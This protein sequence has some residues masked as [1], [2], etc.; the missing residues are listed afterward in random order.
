MTA[1]GYRDGPAGRLAATGLRAA[2]VLAAGVLV[3]V[4]GLAGQARAQQ[5]VIITEADCLRLVK[6]VPAPDVEYAPGVDVYGRPVPP[7]DLGRG[8]SD[9]KPPEEI[10][11]AIEVE[12]RNFLGGPEADARAASAA[13]AA[14]DRAANA[15]A[16]AEV[17]AGEAETAAA[18]NPANEVLATAAAAARA[19]ADAADA[20]VTAE[21]KAAA[22]AEAAAAATGAAA[23]DPGNVPL[24]DAAA[25]AETTAAEATAASAALSEEFREAARIGQFLGKPVIGRVTVKDHQVYYN[26]RP[27]L[28]EDE[29]AIAAACQKQLR[30]R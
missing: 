1:H 7:A 19:G 23:A 2:G 22:A 16:L 13:V 8:Y 11:F 5:T 18:A 12:L 6:H 26:G 28:D 24:A 30:G 9:I 25:A 20:A 17:A 15:A 10:T 3:A 14:A 21:G 27:L 29:A 4:W